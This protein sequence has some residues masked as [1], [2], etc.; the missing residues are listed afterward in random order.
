M[1]IIS[2]CRGPSCAK[3]NEEEGK[4]QFICTSTRELVR[5]LATALSFIMQHHDGAS[6]IGL[7]THCDL[8]QRLF[9]GVPSCQCCMIV[10]G[11]KDIGFVSALSVGRYLA[12]VHQV[13]STGK[14]NFN[15][16]TEGFGY[17]HICAF[18]NRL[19]CSTSRLRVTREWSFDGSSTARG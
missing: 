10:N 18:L 6:I 15:Q 19:S 4:R 7:T 14:W 13:C 3:S 2:N 17:M 8:I 16:S 1:D 11:C 5:A 9:D 12:H